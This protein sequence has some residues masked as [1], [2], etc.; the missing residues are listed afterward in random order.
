[1][2]IRSE[3]TRI[4]E[5][6]QKEIL[7]REKK[8]HDMVEQMQKAYAAATQN[9]HAKMTANMKNGGLGD[10]KHRQALMDPLKEME[11]EL[12]R[13]RKFLSHAEVRPDIAGWSPRG[14]ATAQTTSPRSPALSPSR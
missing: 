7:P 12:T 10:D 11:S 6:L 4:V 1:M 9:M 8:M 5:L 3:L 13:I 14:R 2:D